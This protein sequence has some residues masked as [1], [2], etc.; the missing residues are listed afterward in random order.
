VSHE[1]VERGMRSY[2]TPGAKE[3]KLR[4]DAPSGSMGKTRQRPAGVEAQNHPMIN[5]F[6]VLRVSSP[7]S[8]GSAPRQAFKPRR[9]A[10]HGLPSQLCLRGQVCR[11]A[12]A[13][14]AADVIIL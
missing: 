7:I 9:P 5:R 2:L 8:C 1:F 3:G 14:D 11:R 10:R 4:Q 12:L 13:F 6:A